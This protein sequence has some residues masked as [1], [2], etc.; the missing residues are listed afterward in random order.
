MRCLKGVLYWFLVD[1]NHVC[2]LVWWAISAHSTL[3]TWRMCWSKRRRASARHWYAVAWCI[4]LIDW[5]IDILVTETIVQSVIY[6]LLCNTGLY[7]WLRTVAVWIYFQ[8]PWC[9]RREDRSCLS[10][11][12]SRTK[13]HT[14]SQA[15]WLGTSTTLLDSPSISQVCL[16]TCGSVFLMNERLEMLFVSSFALISLHAVLICL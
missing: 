15:M 10:R 3:S 2:T 9:D 1:F 14:L 16:C 5:L 12:S 4:D 13:D 8:V 11:L 6:D 7:L